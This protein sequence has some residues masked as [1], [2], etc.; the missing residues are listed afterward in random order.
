MRT[1]RRFFCPAENAVEQS[2]CRRV[3]ERFRRR[4]LSQHANF[5][6]FPSFLASLL[7]AKF[8]HLF[9]RCTLSL[10]SGSRCSGTLVG[11]LTHF[12]PGSALI[13]FLLALSSSGCCGA[14]CAEPV[15]GP[16]SVGV[17][18]VATEV[19]ASGLT[20]RVSRRSLSSS[21]LPCSGPS[22]VPARFRRDRFTNV[23]RA[24]GI[25]SSRRCGGGKRWRWWSAGLV[26]RTNWFGFVLLSSKR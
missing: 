22:I 5:L 17:F 19:S 3:S 21:C 9:F 13:L 20:A 7:C 8:R 2:R 23:N 10:I 1:A 25:C 12:L 6:G 16:S 26:C 18:S 15:V 4:K 11:R 14:G 24:S